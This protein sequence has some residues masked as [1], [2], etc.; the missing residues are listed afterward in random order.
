MYK[1]HNEN[2]N[3]YHIPD[4][5]IRAIRLALDIPYYDVVMMLQLNGDFYSCDCLNKVCY[6]KLLDH[7]YRLPHYVCHGRTVEEV[8]ENF[9]DDILLIRIEGHLTCSIFGVVHDIWNCEDEIVTDFWIVPK[10]YM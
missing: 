8:A 10:E 7:D 1:Y 3:G 5:V 6:E 9:I 2:P 4:C